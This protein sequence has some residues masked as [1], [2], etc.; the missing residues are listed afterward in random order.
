MSSDTQDLNVKA[1]RTRRNI[2]KMGA[3]LGS[4]ALTL[5]KVDKTFAQ[6]AVSVPPT[7]IGRG[8]NCFLRGTTILTADGGHK[9]EDLAIGV[10]LPTV[11]GGTRPIQ[12]IGRYPF[13]KSDPSKPWL[14]DVRPIRIA[15]SAL[16]PNVPHADL[17]VTQWHGLFID[18]V[19]VTAGSLINETTITLYEARELNELEFFHI[20]L[21]SHDVIYAEGAPVETL[22]NV[23][24]RA[25]NFAEYFRIYGAPT[26]A[27]AP[28]VPILSCL[29]RRSRFTSHFRSAI[30]WIDCR[31]Q[32][33]VIRDRLEER[34]IMLSRQ[35]EPSL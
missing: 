20:K 8:H 5:A 23:D 4:A 1:Q 32:I 14:K 15:R 25:V 28:C 29:G 22:L 9:I 27:E 18:D 26:G 31:R 17:Y 24:E 13:R 7:A 35:L 34:G 12:W 30:S 2:L 21:D 19:L 6:N 11:F 10:L 3:I 16:A 33:D